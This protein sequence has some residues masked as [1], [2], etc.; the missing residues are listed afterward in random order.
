MTFED[1]INSQ[2]EASLAGLDS[3][4]SPPKKSEEYQTP[5]GAFVVDLPPPNPNEGL[6]YQDQQSL[7]APYQNPVNGLTYNLPGGYEP[8]VPDQTGLPAPADWNYYHTDPIGISNRQVA[9]TAASVKAAEDKNFL[10]DVL[11]TAWDG[12]KNLGQGIIDDPRRLLAGVDPLSTRA[13]NEVTGE[14]YA[15]LISQMGGPG[16]E[17]LANAGNERNNSGIQGLFRGIDTA[18]GV[19]GGAAAA[20]ALGSLFGGGAAVPSGTLA[21]EGLI[22]AAGGLTGGAGSSAGLIAGTASTL[23]TVVVTGTSGLGA[24][25]GAVGGGLAA[26]AIP[27]LPTV[28]VTASQPP[29]VDVPAGIV[30]GSLPQVTPAPTSE[31]PPV[32]VVGE[33]PPDANPTDVL[34]GLGGAGAAT[35][36]PPANNPPTQDPENP[37]FLDRIGLGGLTP[38]QLLGLGVGISSLFGGGGGAPDDSAQR[39]APLPALTAPQRTQGL[40]QYQPPQ[41]IVMPNLLPNPTGRNPNGM[42]M[43]RDR[44]FGQVLAPLRQAGWGIPQVNPAYLSGIN[45]FPGGQIP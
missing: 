44:G 2:L 7:L 28:E 39:N 26:S 32:E 12:V 29:A 33:F 23:P 3:F 20:P 43:I 5:S 35:T 27:Q 15:P 13:F 17:A 45:Q 42:P 6:Q 37:S 19:F 38:Q 41:P 25:L 36:N 24:G 18:A 40:G 16:P 34:A 21:A 10:G 8:Q 4:Y 11:S 9:E 22:D 30:G 31:L 1:F 14:D